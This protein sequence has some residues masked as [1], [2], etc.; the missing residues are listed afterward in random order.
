M[1]LVCMCVCA[2]VQRADSL[3]ID[4][5]GPASSDVTADDD[6]VMPPDDVT[7]LHASDVRHVL[8][9]VMSL[10]DD[11]IVD[12]DVIAS[13]EHLPLVVYVS[14]AQL[15][16][17]AAAASSE[18]G[19]KANSKGS[20]EERDKVGGLESEKSDAGGLQDAVGDLDSAGGGD[21]DG[22]ASGLESTASGLENAG[23]V[24]GL[25]SDGDVGGL[26]GAAGGP[27]GTV[28]GLASAG[29]LV[30][31]RLLAA[32]DSLRHSEHCHLYN[33]SSSHAAG[34]PF[35]VRHDG[36]VTEV[37]MLASQSATSIQRRRYQLTVVC[38][39]SVEQSGST[40]DSSAFRLYLHVQLVP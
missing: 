39:Q 22:D 20:G 23:V 6:D 33:S 17:A 2:C 3:V 11:V 13:S 40:G 27:D 30:L 8:A 1:I 12:S 24:G 26:M 14:R 37:L 15:A 16:Q 38:E 9:S 10:R 32:V 4:V 28:G 36:D 25:E 29:G 35:S 18:T 31:V 34:R 19:L 5:T 21:G 7:L